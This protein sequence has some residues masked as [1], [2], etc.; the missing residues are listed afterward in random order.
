MLEAPVATEASEIFVIF[1]VVN[2]SL[3]NEFSFVPPDVENGLSGDGVHSVE[4]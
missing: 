2:Q 1:T 4:Q 3:I